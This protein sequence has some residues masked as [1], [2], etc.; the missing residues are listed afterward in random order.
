MLPAAVGPAGG[1]FAFPRPSRPDPV[2]I[3]GIKSKS[4]PH[5]MDTTLLHPV[6]GSGL[7][8]ALLS[9]SRA[10]HRKGV[11]VF[12]ALAAGCARDDWRAIRFPRTAVSDDQTRRCS[13]TSRRHGCPLGRVQPI[14]AMVIFPLV[15]GDFAGVPTWRP[16]SRLRG[17]RPRNL[18]RVQRR[19]PGRRRVP[20]PRP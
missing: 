16:L 13:A 18:V 6:S 20:R 17:R 15:F 5:V 12:D 1:R 11:G 2:R 9:N 19:V 3:E 14:M 7:A 8:T 4:G 10:N